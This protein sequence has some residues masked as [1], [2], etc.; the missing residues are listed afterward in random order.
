MRTSNIRTFPTTSAALEPLSPPTGW[1]QEHSLASCLKEPAERAVE[2][3][4]KGS[5][6]SR[7]AHCRIS[8]FSALHQTI[9]QDLK[10]ST[11]LQFVKLVNS[12]NEI[13]GFELS[14]DLQC[15]GTVVPILVILEILSSPPLR[16][17]QLI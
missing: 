2:V 3:A 6:H 12:G 7:P 4:C 5:A 17:A 14:P 9:K 11:S 8:K 16:L 10:I 13:S 1:L 15:A